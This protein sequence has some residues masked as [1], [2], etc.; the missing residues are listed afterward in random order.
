M[1]CDPVAGRLRL[2][3]QAYTSHLQKGKLLYMEVHGGRDSPCVTLE[4]VESQ[5]WTPDLLTPGREPTPLSSPHSAGS[6]PDHPAGTV[7]LSVTALRLGPG[8]VKPPSSQP[9]WRQETGWVCK[10][11]LKH[12]P[13]HLFFFFLKLSLMGQ[14]P[15]CPFPP[16][17]GLHALYSENKASF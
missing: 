16:G 4:C 13:S 10:L 2:Q 9:P 1:L 6:V 17:T 12:P 11:P 15:L 8:K 14:L 5:A 3:A 7:C